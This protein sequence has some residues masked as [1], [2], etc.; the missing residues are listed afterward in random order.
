MRKEHCIS[1]LPAAGMKPTWGL[2]RG[3]ASGCGTASVGLISKPEGKG[4]R[5]TA[6]KGAGGGV[7]GGV[8]SLEAETPC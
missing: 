4:R 2:A 6:W 3:G 5:V 7:G 1:G 8:L